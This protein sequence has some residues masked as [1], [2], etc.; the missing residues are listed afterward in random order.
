MSSRLLVFAAL[1]TA[2]HFHAE[3]GP[4]PVAEEAADCPARRQYLEQALRQDHIDAADLTAG[5]ARSRARVVCLGEFHF[6]KPSGTFAIL[7]V[8]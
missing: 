3:I 8:P 1:F 4:T 2:F 6:Q 7:V 5:L